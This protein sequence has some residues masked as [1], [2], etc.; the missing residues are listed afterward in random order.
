MSRLARKTDPDTSHAA[1]IYSRV[2][3]H[4]QMALRALRDNGPMTS[5]EVAAVTN[6]THAQAWRRLSDLKNEGKVY[7][8]GERR[9]NHSGRYAV[10]WGIGRKNDQIIQQLLMWEPEE[11]I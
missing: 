6:L 9:K 8:T 2:R 5:E 4:K 1:P 11:E 7:D 3:Q 10:V